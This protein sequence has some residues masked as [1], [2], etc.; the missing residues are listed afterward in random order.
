MFSLT[1]LFALHIIGYLIIG[2]SDDSTVPSACPDPDG[3]DAM[4]A[5]KRPWHPVQ[6]PFTF[7]IWRRVCRIVTRSAA[8][9]MTRSIG[10]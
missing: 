3:T 9:A 1:L 10:L 4:D 8:S 2:F 6:S 7:T 5:A